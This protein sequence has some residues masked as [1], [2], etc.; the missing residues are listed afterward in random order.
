MR[1]EYSDELADEPEWQYGMSVSWRLHRN[2]NIA[3]DYL[4]GD[5]KDGFVTDDNDNEL[6]HRN[7]LAAQLA[8]E[9]QGISDVSSCGTGWHDDGC[10]DQRFLN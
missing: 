4:Y 1:L 8:I 5:Y 7:L 2:I 3:V 6:R 10:V 9:F